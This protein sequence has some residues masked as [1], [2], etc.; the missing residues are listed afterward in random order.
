MNPAPRKGPSLGLRGGAFRKGFTLVEVMVATV[1]L[2]MIILGILL[3][4][5]T[6]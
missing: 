3:M 1:L 2:S 6:E 5:Y 4:L